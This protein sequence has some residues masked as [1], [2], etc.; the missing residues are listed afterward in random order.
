MLLRRGFG[1]G[2]GVCGGDAILL[3]ASLVYGVYCMLYT[4]I[5]MVYCALYT[6]LHTATSPGTITVAGYMKNNPPNALLRVGDPS[7]LPQAVAA[8]QVLD[9]TE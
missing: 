9:A 3:P 8:Y 6:L 2:F 1:L 4:A 7:A 5:S